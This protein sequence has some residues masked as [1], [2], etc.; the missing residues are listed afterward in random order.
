MDSKHVLGFRRRREGKTDYKKRINLLASGKPRL[1]IRVTGKRSIA[2]I[3]EY[4]PEGDRT[5]VHASSDELKGL[6]WTGSLKNVPSAY[7]TGFLCAKRAEKKN[8]KSAVLDMGLHT[9]VKASRVFAA[10]SGALAGGIA[11]PHDKAILPDDSRA[12]GKHINDGVVKMFAAV[13]AKIA[14]Q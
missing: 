8:I 9:P 1:V 14:G 6:G 4:V 5:V 12:Q 10:L 3:L 13:K 7:L 11:V 2:H